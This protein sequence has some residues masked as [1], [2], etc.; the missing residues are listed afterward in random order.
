MATKVLCLRCPASVH[1]T[2]ATRQTSFGSSDQIISLVCRLTLWG[3]FGL[4]RYTLI[5]TVLEPI[6]APGYRDY[7]GV[8]EQSVEDGTGDR[9]V[10]KELSP[11]LDDWMLSGW[12]GFRDA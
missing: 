8:M 7:F 5:G 10:A 3:G 4:G 2:N 9:D 12:S 11:F 1:S 6:A